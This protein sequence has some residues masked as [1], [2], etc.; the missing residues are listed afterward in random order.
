MFVGDV[1]SFSP[2]N[3]QTGT[4]YDVKVYA[5]YGGGSSRALEGQGTTRRSPRKHAGN[6]G[7]NTPH[8][9]LLL[10]LPPNPYLLTPTS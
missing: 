9:Y 2:H 4:T 1:T 10:S 5:K 6:H 7:N 8:P 3:L